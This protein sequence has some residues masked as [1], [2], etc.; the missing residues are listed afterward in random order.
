M[1]VNARCRTVTLAILVMAS[2]FPALGQDFDKEEIHTSSLR[3]NLYLLTG[4]GGNVVVF[5]GTDGALIVD[6][7]YR[8]LNTKLMVAIE[9]ITDSSVRFVINSHWHSDHTGG[10]EMLGAAGA[11]IIAH[12]NTGEQMTRDSVMS[13]YGPQAAYA[14][15]GHAK[16]TY[17]A[18]M[19]LHH[20]GETIDLVH[21]GPSHTGG[22][23]VVFFRGHNILM[24]GDIFVGF[25]YRPPY[26]DDLNEG[27]LKGM[28]AGTEAILG[29]VDDKTIVIPG[30]GEVATRADLVT[31][32]GRLVDLR[33]R[34]KAAIARGDSEDAV[35]A[36]KPVGN[37]ARAGKGTDRWVRVVYRE[38]K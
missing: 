13:L 28:I 36:S 26:F 27:S 9:K 2:S 17:S 1:H 5:T 23:T 8:E 6:D 16:I 38:Y 10:N 30:H 12:E 35:V 7:E 24:T 25:D 3:D 4:I 29:L 34:I 31:Y 22:D 14:P 21:P 33:E 18:S 11:I 19:Q 20:N 15:A 32:H 37:F